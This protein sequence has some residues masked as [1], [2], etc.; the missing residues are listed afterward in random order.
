MHNNHCALAS[1]VDAPSGN[2]L[3]KTPGYQ[4]D[5]DWKLLYT[6]VIPCHYIQSALEKQVKESPK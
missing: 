5:L 4:Q 2:Q 6:F 1:C 3:Y